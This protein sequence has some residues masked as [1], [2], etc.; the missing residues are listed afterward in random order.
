[1]TPDTL[2]E[3][4]YVELPASSDPRGDYGYFITYRH[5][6]GHGCEIQYLTRPPHHADDFDAIAD[7]LRAAR[8]P[9]SPGEIFGHAVFISVDQISG[10][11]APLRVHR[12]TDGQYHYLLTLANPQGRYIN[13][14]YTTERL[15]CDYPSL[16][17][18]GE[19]LPANH[20]IVKIKLLEAPGH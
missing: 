7:A 10:P 6:R 3:Y 12:S 9:L 19:L 2:P 11:A 17:A 8:P 15:F 13:R 18:L 1:M 4:V 16:V 14:Y 5:D 20:G